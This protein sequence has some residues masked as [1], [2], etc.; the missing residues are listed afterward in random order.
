MKASLLHGRR[1]VLLWLCC[2]LVALGITAKT[3]YVADLSAFLPTNPS[4]EQSV[5][6][7]QLRGG[8]AARLVLLGI[9]G[10][11]TE[12]RRQASQSLAKTLRESGLFAAVHNGDNAGFE[13]TGRHSRTPRR[14][15]RAHSFPA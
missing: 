12:A 14:S 2:V 7:D 9:E 5:L 3:N 10:G 4:A 11:S 8:V 1:A 13:A 15:S 6:L